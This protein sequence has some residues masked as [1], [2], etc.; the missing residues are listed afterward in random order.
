MKSF[1]QNIW[2]IFQNRL[3]VLYIVIVMMFSVITVK[4]FDL[5]IVKGDFYNK[6]VATTTLQKVVVSAPRGAIYD[7]Y[8]VPLA[9]NKSSFT[10]N[11]DASITVENQN[12][13][14][15]RLI[16]LLE[17]NGEDIVDDFP[18]SKTKPFVFEFDGS[19]NQEKRWKKDM[20][21]EENLTAEECFNKLRKDFSVDE[22]WSDEDARKI[23]SLQCQ[24]HLKRYSKYIPVV[25]AY[26]VKNET[27]A[28]IEEEKR[29]YPGIYIDVEALRNYP[30]GKYFSHLLGYIRGI[31]ESELAEYNSNGDYSLNDLIGK[32]GIEKAFEKQLRGKNGKKYVE[33]GSFEKIYS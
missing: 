7:R 26:D 6:Q 13:V 16:N 10:V 11:I 19:Q 20:G 31:T 4:L 1:F 3:V 29:N 28:A 14:F 21:L 30:G 18:I 2:K 12:D 8:G 27:I 9:I 33:V 5:Q 22:K 15:V 32:D 25:V 24:L 17:R 23:L